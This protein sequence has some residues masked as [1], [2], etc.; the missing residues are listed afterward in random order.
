[1]GKLFVVATP[2]G[3]LGDFSPRAIETLKN[4]KLIA[5]EDT[6][7]S[8]KLLNHFDIHTE[9]C[10]YH[11]FNENSKSNDIIDRIRQNNIDVALISDCGTPCISD[12]GSILVNKAIKAG[13]EV[14]SIPGPSAII[15]AL[16]KSGFQIEDFAFYGFIERKGSKQIEVLKKISTMNSISVLYESPYRIKKLISNVQSVDAES[17]V[18]VCRELSKMF[19]TTYRGTPGTV[20]Q[21]LEKDP[22]AEKGEYCIIIQWTS[23]KIDNFS[24][25]SCSLEALIFDAMLNKQEKQQIQQNLMAMG[26][27]RN[28]IYKAQLQIYEFLTA[29]S[30]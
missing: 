28:D 24:N 4:V 2:I 12:P 22:N 25:H 18:C 26:Y 6:R 29:Q 17:K 5:A 27:K 19:E 9:L 7:V 14:I 15:T 21:Q 23:K 16:S 1:M 13:I 30:D 3:N 10:S 20:L 11:K 8:Q